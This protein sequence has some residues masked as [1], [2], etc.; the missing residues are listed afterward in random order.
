[1]R[2]HE[3]LAI[4]NPADIAVMGLHFFTIAVIG[5]LMAV[6]KL[7]TAIRLKERRSRLLCLIPAGISCLEVPWGTVLGVM[8]FIVLG[9]PSVRELFDAHH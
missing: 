1:M 8:T 4:A 2:I 7:M 3:Q 9:R 6:L 5:T